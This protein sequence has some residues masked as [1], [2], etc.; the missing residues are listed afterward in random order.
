MPLAHGIDVSTQD[1]C[2]SLCDSG[3]PEYFGW[4]FADFP[5]TSFERFGLPLPYFYKVDDGEFGSRLA[6]AP[7]IPV[8]GISVWHPSFRLGYTPA[9]VYYSTRNTLATA[10]IRGKLT[11]DAIKGFYNDVLCDTACLKYQYA[12]ARLKAAEDFLEGPV[13]VFESFLDGPEKVPDC[14]WSDP[15]ELRKELDIR[16]SKER[17]RWFR[18][19]SMNGLLL[20]AKGDREASITDRKTAH[21]YR[22][23]KVL[24]LRGENRGTICSRDRGRASKDV[25]AARKMRRRLKSARK[26]LW[27]EYA[28]A[29][30]KYS[31]KEWW[32]SVFSGLQ[33]KRRSQ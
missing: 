23:G 8:P 22:A 6:G 25:R 26:M 28:A 32:E 29:F 27:N 31:S 1:G 2:L 21:F 11:K 13:E 4:W 20:S 14:E 16:E 7:E 33:K 9:S 17:P 24:Y 19:C 15:E 3:I 10:A 30:P 5:R 12:E 18:F